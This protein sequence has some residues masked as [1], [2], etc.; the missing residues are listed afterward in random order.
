MP[1]Q[2]WI[3]LL[4]V[5]ITA[6]AGFLGYYLA[7]RLRATPL[8]SDLAKAEERLRSVESAQIESQKHSAQMQTLATENTELKV[9]LEYERVGRA[10]DAKT[11]AEIE[12]WRGKAREE[13]ITRTERD[14]NNQALMGARIEAAVNRAKLE[15][16]WAFKKRFHIERKPPL[17]SIDGIVFKTYFAVFDE[18]ILFDGLPITPW[19]TTRRQ[20]DRRLDRAELE[21]F[22]AATSAIAK[23]F[24]QVPELPDVIKK[25]LS[26]HSGSKEASAD[27]KTNSTMV[28]LNQPAITIQTTN[29]VPPQ[30]DSPAQEP[31]SN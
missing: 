1:G 27:K 16:E 26:G 25:L 29:S 4:F 17:L 19:I 24:L 2:Y 23:T 11:S 18:R 6:L 22:V 7:F 20:V 9:R 8:L 28:E 21:A 15:A 31:R 5:A 10:T 12:K 30:E 3:A 13:E 14:A